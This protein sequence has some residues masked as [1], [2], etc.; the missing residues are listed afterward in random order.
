MQKKYKIL[1]L[2]YNPVF[3]LDL[4]GRLK[5]YDNCNVYIDHI[6]VFNSMESKKY[7]A[8]VP[9]DFESQEFINN[10]NINCFKCG[11]NIY[12]LLDNKRKINKIFRKTPL[13]N[14]KLI[15]TLEKLNK[16]SINKFIKKYPSNDYIIKHSKGYAGA[17]QEIFNK[18]NINNIDIDTYKDYI[19]QPKL[20]NFK[21]YSFDAVCQNGEIIDFIVINYKN[22]SNFEYNLLNIKSLVES[23]I[24][25]TGKLYDKIIS[26]S[27]KII[28]YTNYSGII[29]IEYIVK[30]NGM[31]L[32]EINPRISGNILCSDN[33]TNNGLYFNSIVI[34]YL[35]EQ[36]IILE[37]KVEYNQ[38]LKG[39]YFS[40]KKIL[41]Y[42]KSFIQITY[43]FI[44]NPYICPIVLVIIIFFLLFLSYIVH[45]ILKLFNC[46]LKTLI[47]FLLDIKVVFM[48][49]I[50]FFFIAVMLF[51]LFYTKLNK[52]T[53]IALKIIEFFIKLIC[54]FN[55]QRGV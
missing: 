47:Y 50:L 27:K 1:I 53:L 31:Y 48:L 17:W 20:T 49:L 37:D 15:P 10:N 34:P 13:K 39:T 3:I 21:L 38:N 36:G 44:F 32:L 8:I 4:Y 43:H 23:E 42:L 33:L 5:T 12:E 22:F 18:N 46:T 6:T 9:S 51:I 55:S 11:E 24:L 52:I 2:Y 29:D 35:K 45:K 26:D 41:F 7:D 30:E 19:L 14:I 25:R 40:Y 54:K 16:N 28:N